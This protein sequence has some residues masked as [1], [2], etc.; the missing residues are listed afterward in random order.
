MHANNLEKVD[1]LKVDCEGGEYDIFYSTSVDTLN[2]CEYMAIEYHDI[3]EKKNGKALY[4][5]LRTT[6]TPSMRSVVYHHH[7]AHPHNGFIT[8]K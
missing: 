5:Y 4:W 1:F 7:P 8:V 3:D 2:K 6:L